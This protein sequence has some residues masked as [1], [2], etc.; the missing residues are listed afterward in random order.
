[1]DSSFGKMGSAGEH[2]PNLI[3]E[4][5]LTDDPDRRSLCSA[6]KERICASVSGQKLQLLWKSMFR[7]FTT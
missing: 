5:D 2:V 7:R 3:I 4:L 6:N 1:M